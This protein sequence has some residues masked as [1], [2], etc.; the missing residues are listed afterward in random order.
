MIN[1]S[2]KEVEVGQ[3]NKYLKV[4]QPLVEM[5]ELLVV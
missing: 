4:M 5:E 1:N 2:S 3:F